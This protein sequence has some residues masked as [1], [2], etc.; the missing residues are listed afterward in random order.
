M[1]VL[2]RTVSTCGRAAT[3]AAARVVCG[4]ESSKLPKS[5]GAFFQ[6]QE[7]AFSKAK[8]GAGFS[9]SVDLPARCQAVAAVCPIPTR[10]SVGV[11]ERAAPEV[12]K[13]LEPETRPATLN[14]RAE[15]LPRS[16]LA[17]SVSGNL[18]ECSGLGSRPLYTNVLAEFQLSYTGTSQAEV[19]A[20]VDINAVKMAYHAA[21]ER[22][23]ADARL[24]SEFAMFTWKAMG[25]VDAAEELYNKAL[26]LAPN[27][28]NIQANHALFLWQCDE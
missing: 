12:E 27:D 15:P 21:L 14:Q 23:P 4:I 8:N 20:T 6:E 13:M 22:S 19:P 9:Q 24:V 10:Q 18:V 25:N 28:S 5:N 7:M 16:F 17:E 3:G 26:E 2:L 1:A 11:L